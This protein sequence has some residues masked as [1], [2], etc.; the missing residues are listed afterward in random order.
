MI[1]VLLVDDHE[2]VRSGVR[3]LLDD[4][5]DIVVVGEASNGEQALELANEC[6]PDVVLMDLSMPGIGG[7]EATR[8]LMKQHPDCKVIVVTVHA[9]EPF[10]K[11][12]LEA[13]AVGYLTKGCGIDEIVKAIKSVSNGTRYIATDI[14][15]Q[16]AL[17]M[18]PDA[19][20]SPFDNLSS[21][22]MQIMLMITQG[23]NAQEISDSLCLSPKT[24][25]TYRRRLFEK[26]GVDNDVELT[27]LAIRHGIVEG[28]R[29][30]N[31]K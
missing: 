10:P 11:R 20:P 14:A 22:E 2:L 16:I 13:G 12:L 29:E 9:E 27:R 7:L 6:Q 18:M 25:S 30:Q 3:R 5:Q 17:S 19:P 21:R 24:V 23:Q 4:S 26:T 28:V 1:K 8:K 31:A 15:Q